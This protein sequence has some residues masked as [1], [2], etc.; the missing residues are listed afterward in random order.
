MLPWS[1]TQHRPEAQT[2]GEVSTDAKHDLLVLAHLEWGGVITLGA[3]M[4]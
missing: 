1:L 4:T 2:E 3:S